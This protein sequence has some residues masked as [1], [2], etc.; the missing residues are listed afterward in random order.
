MGNRFDS[1]AQAMAELTNVIKEK[2]AEGREREL[3]DRAWT[4]HETVS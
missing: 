1:I 2:K 4:E 3:G